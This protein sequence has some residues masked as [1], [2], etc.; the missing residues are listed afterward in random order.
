[1]NIKIGPRKILVVDNDEMVLEIM[2]LCLR[3]N[4]SDVTAVPSA[5]QALKIL[6]NFPEDFEALITDYK[7]PV[8]NGVEFIQELKNAGT[9]IPKIVIVSSM[10]DLNDDI[11]DLCNKYEQLKTL[12]KPFTEDELIQVLKD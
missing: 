11:K 12:T 9:K 4:G 7:M 2:S 6:E 1:M 10:I 8:M 5:E 3:R